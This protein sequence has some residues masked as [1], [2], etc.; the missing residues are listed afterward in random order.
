MK[1]WS[2][3]PPLQHRHVR[4]TSAIVSATDPAQPRPAD[5]GWRFRSRRSY[6]GGRHP[7][8]S[9]PAQRS[10]VRPTS[11]AVFVTG[12]AQLRSAWAVQ[13]LGHW[14]LVQRVWGSIPRSPSTFRDLFIVHLRTARSVHWYWVGLRHGNLGSFPSGAFEFNCVIILGKGYV[15]KN[16]P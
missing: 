10:D 3:A 9:P 15:R 1:V 8:F 14:P 13:W 6:D 16:L 12:P 4:P 2:D 5:V 11:T 7:L